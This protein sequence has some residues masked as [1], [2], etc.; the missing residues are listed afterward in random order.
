MKHTRT[1]YAV[2]Q[3]YIIGITSVNRNTDDFHLN[4][5]QYTIY[6]YSAFIE[7]I[8]SFITAPKVKYFTNILLP[9]GSTAGHH[10]VDGCKATVGW[11]AVGYRCN[12]DQLDMLSHKTVQWLKYDINQRLNS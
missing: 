3:V 5:L 2:Y 6:P 10:A 11:D 1:E 9:C 7:Q 8:I 4:S 12:A